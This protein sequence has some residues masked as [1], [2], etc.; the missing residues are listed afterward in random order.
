MYL[1]TPHKGGS[2]ELRF[3]RAGSR[4]AAKATPIISAV[5]VA[6]AAAYLCQPLPCQANRFQ[7][8]EQIEGLLV[9]LGAK[10]QFPAMT[11][12]QIISAA[13]QQYVS[14][15]DRVL[16]L[17]INGQARAYPA[18]LGWWHEIVNDL[19]GGQ[20]V[21]V[22]FCP[23][24]GTKLA[25]AATDSSGGQI[26]YGVS[27]LLV[28]ANLVLY[29]RADDALYPQMIHTGFA[30]D[31]KGVQLELLP[32]LETTWSEWKRLHPETTLPREGTGLERFPRR[33]RDN[34]PTES[35]LSD[36]YID[37][38]ADH[39][40]VP[41]PPSGGVDLRLPP[42]DFVLGVCY[43]SDT[44]A[45]H[46]RTLPEP[47]AINDL[48][49][50]LPIAVFFDGRSQTAA[51]FSAW[52]GDDV[53]DFYALD[54]SAKEPLLFRDANT[55]STWNLE[56]EAVVGPL[57]GTRLQMAPSYNAMWFAWSAFFP[58]TSIW[59]GTGIIEP[60]T[61]VAEDP[62]HRVPTKTATS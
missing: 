34:Y 8:L 21:S 55:G 16:G 42:K 45:Y 37:Y 62:S 19:L 9:A 12:P 35:Y 43:G 61:A 44:R 7:D 53:L 1:N 31:S 32:A 60:T 51:A 59:A 30:G 18:S 56:G 48:V 41:Y 52:A 54:P 58:R 20:F 23:L 10:D 24:T 27:G 57:Q 39:T 17:I 25:L 49:G 26:E 3:C 47:V 46:H 15:T 13:E 6:L 33:V 28:Y 14:D 36:P 29:D 4:P 40:S 38:R 50:D 5:A 11:N 2:A 22:T